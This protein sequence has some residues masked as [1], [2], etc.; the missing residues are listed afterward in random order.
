VTSGVGTVFGHIIFEFEMVCSADCELYFMMDIN[1]KSW[2]GSKVRQ[3]YTYIVTKNTSVSYTWAFQRTNQASENVNGMVH[4]YSISVS[5]TVDGVSSECQ[6]CALLSQPS[7][8][9]CVPCPPGHYIH[10]HTPASAQSAPQHTP[11]LTQHPEAC[12]PCGPSTKINKVLCVHCFF[13]KMHSAQLNVCVFPTLIT[14]CLRVLNG[15][16][17][18]SKGTKYYHLCNISLCGEVRRRAVCTDNTGESANVVESFICQSTIIPS[19]GRGFRTAPSSQSISLADTFLGEY[20][21][22]H[23]LSFNGYIHNS[24]GMFL[25]CSQC[26]AGTCD[27]CTSRACPQ[28]TA[29]DYHQIEAAC[30]GYHIQRVGKQ[31]II[32]IR[33]LRSLWYMAKMGVAIGVFTATLL[34]SITCYFWKKNKRLEYKYSKLV[35]SSNKECEL[36][37]FGQLCCDGGRGGG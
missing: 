24:Y 21:E 7:G 18:T 10:T 30:K 27:G 8:S 32:A 9:L 5:N 29:T 22:P 31:F 15:P 13:H 2:E 19:S 3:S 26:P 16:S 23:T 11:H 33:H 34:F 6:A 36:P 4:I 25:C 1:R 17:F 37:M 20:T 28:C 14:K 35:M 12:K